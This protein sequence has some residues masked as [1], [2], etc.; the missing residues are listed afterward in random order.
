MGIL[1]GPD[2][3][4]N[5]LVGLWD[6]GNI[7]SYPGSGSV[8]YDLVGPNH[9]TND[10]ATYNS[11]GYFYVIGGDNLDCQT[12]NISI[13]TA[14]TLTCWWRETGVGTGSP[15]V[16]ELLETGSIASYGHALAPGGDGTLRAW[17]DDGGSATSRKGDLS[18]ATVWPDDV[19]YYMVMTYDSPNSVLYMNG[20]V[21][22]TGSGS[23]ADL[24][25]INIIT[26]GAISDVN[27]YTHSQHCFQGDIAMASIYNRALTAKEVLYNYDM[28]KIRFNNII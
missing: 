1:A 26:L 10:G 27:T 7:D 13:S 12:A 14:I 16:L 19:W 11:N 25:D 6:A 24:D 18:D 15:R 3:V 17:L 9:L 28:Q 20:E 4:T 22:D 5:G 21:A 8:M 23:S 2:I